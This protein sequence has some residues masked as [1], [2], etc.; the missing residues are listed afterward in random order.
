MP[1]IL[2]LVLFLILSGCSGTF[3]RMDAWMG[4]GQESV[5]QSLGRQPDATGQDALGDW[6]RWRRHAD[7]P[8]SDRLTFQNGK[9]VGYASDCG[10]WGGWFAPQA[11]EGQP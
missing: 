8:C 3:K 10:L 1:L 9:V 4:V 7:G 5:V 6:M 2:T 11:P